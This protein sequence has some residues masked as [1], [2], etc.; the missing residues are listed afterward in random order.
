MTNRNAAVVFIHAFVGWALCAAT[1]GIGMATTTPQT[2]LIIHAVAAPIFFAAVSSVYFS[3]FPY[4]SPLA[5]AVLFVLFV[6][7]VDFL[8][9]GLLVLRS[10]AMFES[11]LG[12]WLPFAL[13]F[14]ST[15]LTGNVFSAIRKP[16]AA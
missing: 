14:G 12:T 4:T 16:G 13:I 10:L 11:V 8:V 9:V 15:F 7:V 1:M 5:T 6:V 3:R 2:A